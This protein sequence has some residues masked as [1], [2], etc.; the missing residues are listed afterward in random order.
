MSRTS[1]RPFAVLFVV[2]GLFAVLL[3]LATAAEPPF[4]LSVESIPA[5]LC[6]TSSPLSICVGSDSSIQV[7]HSR[8]RT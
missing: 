4:P 3:G 7:A 5:P 1:L 6:I 8:A 2:L